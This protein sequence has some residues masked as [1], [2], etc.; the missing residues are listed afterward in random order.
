MALATST[1]FSKRSTVYRPL[2]PCVSL[3]NA[4]ETGEGRVNQTAKK[5]NY[6]RLS[7]SKARTVFPLGIVCGYVLGNQELKNA[8]EQTRDRHERTDLASVECLY[9]SSVNHQ[10]KLRWGQQF[11]RSLQPS[12]DDEDSASSNSSLESTRSENVRACFRKLT[13]DA[14]V[15]NPQTSPNFSAMSLKIKSCQLTNRPKTI[16][17]TVERNKFLTVTK[18]SPQV[19][20]TCNNS[21]KSST[22]HLGRVSDG[23]NIE[24][25]VEK[26]KI[27]NGLV[28]IENGNIVSLKLNVNRKKGHGK[29][30]KKKNPEL[31]SFECVRKFD[32]AIEKL[33][34]TNQNLQ[35]CYREMK[36]I[37]LH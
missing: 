1:D 17:T 26:T 12:E 21:G 13:A 11:I 35:L 9:T 5:S 37:E 15:Y 6:E 36:K 20:V 16:S 2:L 31:R 10:G 34:K 7:C 3:P 23:K 18:K 27:D 24:S 19:L 4:L 28:V 29:T 22:A 33:Y 25:D 14:F 8:I 30:I 32:K